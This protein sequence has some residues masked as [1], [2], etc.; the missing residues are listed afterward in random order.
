[1]KMS[2]FQKKT[3]NSKVEVSNLETEIATKRKFEKSKN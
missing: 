1:M 3:S 2:I